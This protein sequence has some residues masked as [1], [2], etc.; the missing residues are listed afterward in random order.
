VIMPCTDR[1]KGLQTAANLLRRAGMPC[2]ILVVIDS[3]RQ[4]FIKTLNDTAARIYVKYIVYLAQDAWPGRN[5][6]KCAYNS[7]EKSQK[8]L[9]AF[10]DGKWSGRIA[11]FGMVRIDWVKKLYNGS[12]FYSGYKSHK[13]DN[14]LTVIARAQ[15]MHE[16]NPECT[17]M[18]Y[19]PE[20]DHGGSNPKDDALFQDR[21]Q[22]SFD[23]AAQMGELKKM[24]RE[25]KVTMKKSENGSPPTTNDS[26]NNKGVSI[27]VPFHN[28]ADN[29]DRLLSSF[30]EANTYSPVE[31]IIVDQGSTANT[32]EVLA[33]YATKGFVRH[34]KCFENQSFFEACNFGAAKARH[35]YLFFLNSAIIHNR[36]ILPEALKNLM[37]DKDSSFVNISLNSK[38]V[39]IYRKQRFKGLPADNQPRKESGQEKEETEIPQ[40]SDHFLST[41]RTPTA[42]IIVCVHNALDDVKQCLNSVLYKTSH[43]YRLILV[44]DGSDTTT[45]EHLKTFNKEQL[46]TVLIHNQEARGYTKAA[47]QGLRESSADYNILLNSDTIVTSRWLERIIE[48]GES[49]P[50]I[51]IIGPLSNAASYQSVPKLRD[52]NGD[53]A[54]NPLPE[55]LAPDHMAEAVYTVSYRTFPKVQFINGFCYAIKKEVLSSVGFLDEQNFPK[56]YGEENDYSV[57]AR[58]AGFSLAIADHVYIHHHKSKSFSHEGRKKLSSLGRKAL[59]N[60]HGKKNILKD[61][62]QCENLTAIEKIR[63]QLLELLSNKQTIKNLLPESKPKLLWLLNGPGGGGGAL[64]IVQEANCLQELGWVSKVAVNKAFKDRLFLN[65]AHF[66][67]EVFVMYKT[68]D[69]LKEIASKYDIVVGTHFPTIKTIKNILDFCPRLIPAYYIQDY[70]PWIINP[71]SKKHKMQSREAFG[72]YTNVKNILGFAKTEWLRQTVEKYHSQIKV[73]K[74]SPGLQT[75]IFR[76]EHN[77]IRKSNNTLNIVA[78]IRPSTPRRA[79]QKTMETLKKI[80]ND[81]RDQVHVSLFGCSQDDP[82]FSSLPKG[83]E[84]ENHGF[85]TTP[86]IAQ[87]LSNSDIFLD[88]STYQA[89]GRTGLEA[90]AMGCATVLPVKGG[91]HEY[92]EH[93]QNCL[94]VDTSDIKAVESALERLVNNNR[95]RAALSKNGVVTASRYSVLSAALSEGNVFLKGYQKHR[96]DKNKKDSKL[97]IANRSEK[98]TERVAAPCKKADPEAANAPVTIILPV[99]NAVDETMQCLH[100]VVK[101]RTI[102]YNILVIDDCSDEPGVP[103]TISVFCRDYPFI[104]YIR[105]EKNIGYTGTI[106][107]G[108]KLSPKGDVILLN[109]DTVVTDCWVE[110][111]AAAAYSRT[112]VA[113]VTPLS[114][115][116]GAFSI[117][118]NNKNNSLLHDSSPEEYNLILESIS[119]QIRPIAPTGNGFCLYITRRAIDKLNSFDQ[120]NFPRGY[121]EEND[122]CQ[123]AIKAGLINIVD[124]STF[125]Y[126]NRSSSFG[127]KKQKLIE[128]GKKKLAVL[129]PNYKQDVTSWLKNDGLRELRNQFHKAV[130][131]PDDTS[132][133]KKSGHNP[134]LYILHDGE[135]G[136]KHTTYDLA[137][138][139]SNQHH[140]LILECNKKY[141]KLKECT[142]ETTTLIKMYCF[143]R[144]WAV[145]DR[146]DFFRQKAINSIIKRYAPSFVHVR[147]FIGNEPEI[148]STFKKNEIPV[149]VSLHD[150]YVLCPTIQLLDAQRKYCKGRCEMA[151]GPCPLTPKWFGTGIA[152]LKDNRVY[153]HRKRFSSQLKHAD[154]LVTTSFYTKQLISEILPG[155]NN[156]NFKIIEHGRNL[157]RSKLSQIPEKDD[158]IRL[159]SFGALGPSKGTKLIEYLLKRNQQCG[160]P[161]EIHLAGSGLGES[162]EMEKYEAVT[163]G[164]Y[165]RKELPLKIKKIAPCLALIL[166]IWPETYCHTLTESWSMGLPVVATDI[167]ALGERI[168]LHGGGW[169]LDYQNPEQCWQ[170]LMEIVKDKKDIAEKQQE[171]EK[172]FIKPEEEMASDYLS[173]YRQLLM[174]LDNMEKPMVVKSEGSQHELN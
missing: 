82:A 130:S 29:L 135:G 120:K 9:L 24:A 34:I 17:L 173:L 30:F 163:H 21:F 160:Y 50:K 7:L 8:G 33:K 45:T 14:E 11:S 127:D 78:M 35:S 129:H 159:V 165:S 115:A 171:A 4:G 56:G 169:L 99:F 139:V 51:G 128:E 140:V 38:E 132:K 19:D 46:G 47:N 155:I 75:E 20:K 76:P 114:N 55:D 106:N 91:T 2:R 88:M 153:E 83:F 101:K 69:E 57:R 53:W 105:N 40:L 109:S 136:V 1:D 125:I 137:K 110:K 62:K 158:K 80:K 148:I 138:Q 18:E 93:E 36:D 141:W 48:C 6:L 104:N 102:P 63:N 94:L 117:P 162:K 25:Y 37:Q 3:T 100:S 81:F 172:I 107:K 13:A 26:L 103:E 74:V 97:K 170:K 85:L 67:K 126:H 23:G 72:S 49:D 156:T 44:N 22:Q 174:P 119:R 134:I 90:M 95:L 123:R 79:P 131:I 167:G 86:Q 122:F 164:R 124:D 108:I 39:T 15:R 150:L 66:S 96:S 61:I 68:E 157:P 32:G 43:P 161:F 16:Y 149:V 145:L 152:E 70:E 54:V 146:M 5:W 87:L 89:F 151:T 12:I 84:F 92:A 28:A 42:D 118:E 116:A 65:Y 73:H 144:Q 52:E 77:K 154:F 31:F 64:S 142:V 60:K 147:H 143:D 113:T 112:D 58:N 98:N 133:V 121:G 71:D 111:M 166:S 59:D 10:N 168:R 41:K 27:I